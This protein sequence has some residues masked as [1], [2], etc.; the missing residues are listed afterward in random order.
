M[1]RQESWWGLFSVRVD[2]IAW[3]MLGII[4]PS[5]SRQR[6]CSNI[7]ADLSSETMRGRPGE[8]IVRRAYLLCLMIDISPD[9]YSLITKREVSSLETS[10]PNMLVLLPRLSTG[11]FL[12][13]LHLTDGC[14]GPATITTELNGRQCWPGREGGGSERERESLEISWCELGLELSSDV[15]WPHSSYCVTH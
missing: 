4:S 7:T 11:K 3:F 14:A 6:A 15:P 8:E 12:S 10:P 2:I 13:L 9:H 1:A 5:C